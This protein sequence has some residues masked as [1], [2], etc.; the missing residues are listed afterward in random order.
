MKK[1]Q[2]SVTVCLLY[3]VFTCVYIHFHS[4]ETERQQAAQEIITTKQLVP[5]C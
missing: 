4:D 1:T 5:V 3:S 2:T